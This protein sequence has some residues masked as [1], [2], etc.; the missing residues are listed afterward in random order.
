MERTFTL[1]KYNATARVYAIGEYISFSR[2]HYGSLLA[3]GTSYI[4]KIN[5]H[6]HVTLANGKVFDKGGSEYKVKFGGLQ[7]RSVESLTDELA[8]REARNSL[9][10]RVRAVEEFITSRKFGSGHYGFSDADKAKL[11]NLAQAV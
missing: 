9:D 4:T 11:V 6:G 2:S 5:G 10:A 3:H 7:L 8:Q 1:C